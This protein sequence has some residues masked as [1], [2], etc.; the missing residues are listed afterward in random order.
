[1]VTYGHIHHSTK[2]H[3]TETVSVPRNVM[4]IEPEAG[5]VARN[6]FGPF[7]RSETLDLAHQVQAPR[8]ECFGPSSSHII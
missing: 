2:V 6:A 1:M 4:D 8:Q 7:V 3:H 5:A